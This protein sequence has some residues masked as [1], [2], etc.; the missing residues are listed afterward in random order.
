MTM[1]RRRM[2]RFVGRS[3]FAV[4]CISLVLFGLNSRW[5]FGYQGGRLVFGV[6][7]GFVVVGAGGNRN[8]RW[9]W[10]R[11]RLSERWFLPDL[12]EV[13]FFPLTYVALSGAA[14]GFVG[15]IRGRRKP[16]HHGLCQA[17]S[18]DL[19]GNESGTC[20]ECGTVAKEP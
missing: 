17:C 9:I 13:V 10:Q 15:W 18:Y 20:P 7:Q 12:S 11:S 8:P 2:W 14:F 3:G 4:A 19:T 1:R 6:S 5:E 16:P